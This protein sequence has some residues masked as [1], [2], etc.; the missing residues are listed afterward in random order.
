[1]SRVRVVNRSTLA[2]RNIGHRKITIKNALQPFP[3]IRDF[4][5]SV[6]TPPW[7]VGPTIAWDVGL[8]LPG[9]ATARPTV[10]QN[11]DRL[12]PRCQPL[13]YLPGHLWAGQQ[14]HM[15]HFVG[16][17]QCLVGKSQVPTGIFMTTQGAV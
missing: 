1:M 11:H 5:R 9:T 12:S 7:D 17:P 2:H 13:H 15:T 4:P 16:D 3:W 6:A 8:R 10:V 14:F